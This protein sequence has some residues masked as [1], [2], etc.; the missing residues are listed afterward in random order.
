MLSR[1][2]YGSGGVRGRSVK[3]PRAEPD[4]IGDSGAIAK[5]LVTSFSLDLRIPDSEKIGQRRLNIIQTLDMGDKPARLHGEGKVSGL[6][7]TSK[8]AFRRLKR[9]NRSIELTCRDA[10]RIPASVEISWDKICRRAR[11]DTS[12][13][14]F[15]C[16]FATH[17]GKLSS[18]WRPLKGAAKPASR[19]LHPAEGLVTLTAGATSARLA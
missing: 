17:C 9:M 19:R 1:Q 3:M 12:T 5:G 14:K 18:F 15:R 16:G 6:L 7:D 8:V 13:L 4:S 11:A 10:S 2:S